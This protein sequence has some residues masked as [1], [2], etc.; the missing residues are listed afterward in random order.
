[1]FSPITI[2]KKQKK[3]KKNL[4]KN[5]SF[6]W[7]C[8]PL[9]FINPSLPNSEI[10][11]SVLSDSHSQ[12]SAK[13]LTNKKM[14]LKVFFYHLFLVETWCSEFILPWSPLCKVDFSSYS[15]PTTSPE[16]KIATFEIHS[17][18]QQH[19][20]LCIWKS[21]AHSQDTSLPLWMFYLQDHCPFSLHC[22]FQNSWWFQ[23]PHWWNF[24]QIVIVVQ[25]LSC[26]WLCDSMDF[27]MPGSLSSTISHSLLKFLP[28]E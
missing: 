19:I 9:D 28:F 5:R 14:Y 8:Q 15:T 2:K 7:W 1:M 25:S 4:E 20:H 27:S 12:S 21:F 23:Q 18:R 6:R 24:Q 16:V 11:S 17:I 22:F 3:K 13:S 26:V 10:S